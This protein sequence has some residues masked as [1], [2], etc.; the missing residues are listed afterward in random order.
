MLTGCGGATPE[1]PVTPPKPQYI[2]IQDITTSVYAGVYKS[3]S[4]ENLIVIDNPLEGETINYEVVGDSCRIENGRVIGHRGGTT[5]VVNVTTSTGRTGSFNIHVTGKNYTST[6]Q[7]AETSEGWFNSVNIDKVD[8]M[9]ESF[10]NGI[11]ISSM[12]ILYDN[13]QRFY[14]KDNK[15]TALPWIL[16]DY[17]VNWVR[18]RLWHDPKDTYQEGGETK[19]FN[20]GG[21]D[22]TTERMLWVAKECKAAGLK[23]QLD[24]HYSDFWTSPGHQVIPKAWRNLT[25]ADQFSD[26][27]YNYTKETIEAFTTGGAKP[28]MVSV[29]NEITDGLIL[30]SS[31]GSQTEPTGGEPNY[32]TTKYNLNS[33][34]RGSF[35]NTSDKN[36]NANFRKY[37]ASGVKAVKDV[38]RNI[39]T[40]VHI[41]KAIYAGKGFIYN[42]FDCLS[43]I[44]IDVY[45]FSVY[46]YYQFDNLS[47]F[48]S[49]MNDIAAR[50]PNKKMCV[51]E[52]S[53]G[54]T[55]EKDTNA[56][57]SFDPA[58]TTKEHPI[59]GY[60]VSVQGQA[61]IVRDI[62]KV[63][64]DLSNG[65]GCFYWEGAWVPQKFSGWADSLSLVSWANQGFFSYNGKPLG[66]LEV[67]N[68]ML[69]K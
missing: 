3:G 33:S 48:T 8:S 25:T 13:G 67:Y 12:K 50:Y 49:A 11:D 56:Q 38:D 28:D 35:T 23:V 63:I 58:N 1:A 36:T 34:I 40:T 16:K 2:F 64:S 14:N 51:G 10:A 30:Q 65:F 55:T 37:V 7:T 20:Y 60:E 45:S 15:E 18:L 27:I 53:Y 26:A 22:C 9:K 44:D 68:K 52:T 66:S 21:G 42:F 61:N 19:Y 24:F 59:S 31:T 29:G 57:N 4:D 17:G 54:F 41:A 47:R 32:V 5:S 43:D 62:S 39:L 69:G 46:P 6:H